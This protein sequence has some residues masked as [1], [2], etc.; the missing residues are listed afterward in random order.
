MLSVDNGQ[1]RVPIGVDVLG[2]SVAEEVAGTHREMPR[3]WRRGADGRQASGADAIQRAGVCVDSLGASA[4]GHEHGR[5]DEEQG[6]N[7]LGKVGPPVPSSTQT[8]SE[9]RECSQEDER[10][11]RC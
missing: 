8:E 7:E 2:R 1:E 5:A 10:R 9:Q 4:V 6:D 11:A 3:R